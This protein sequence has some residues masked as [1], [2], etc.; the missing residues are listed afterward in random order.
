MNGGCFHSTFLSLATTRERAKL[1]LDLLRL[2][3]TIPFALL[4]MAGAVL[5]LLAW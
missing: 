5:G 2:A 4:I 3:L 1:Y